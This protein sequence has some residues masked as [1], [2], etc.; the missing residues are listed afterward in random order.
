MLFALVIAFSV[1]ITTGAAAVAA[2]DMQVAARVVSFMDNPPT[3]TLRVGIV[4]APGNPQSSADAAQVQQ[5][6]GSGLRAGNLVLLPVMVKIDEVASANVGLFFLTGGVGAEA[7]KLGEVARTRRVP[8]VTLDLAEVR[9]GAC[10]VGVR[11]EP[12]VEILVNRA[13]ATSSG[14]TF[15]TAFRMLITEF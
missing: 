8:C 1:G 5:M 2:S 13:A 12:R 10:A 6:L 7:A 3:G 4:Y 11:S 9:A 14:I 15:S